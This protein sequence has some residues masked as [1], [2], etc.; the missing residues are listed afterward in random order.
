MYQTDVTVIP[1]FVERK[2]YK[3]KLVHKNWSFFNYGKFCFELVHTIEERGRH[4]AR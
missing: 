4:R 2:C 1:I 3:N